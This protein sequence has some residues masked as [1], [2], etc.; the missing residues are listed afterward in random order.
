MKQAVSVP[1]FANGNILFHSDIDRCLEVTGADAV[2]SAE[3]NLYNPAIFSSSLTPI[4]API[5]PPPSSEVPEPRHWNIATDTGLHP[6]HTTLALEYL[7]IVKSLKTP[8]SNGAIKAHLFKL[9]RPA[10][11]RET[12]IRDRLGRM[13]VDK[14]KER[15]CVNKWEE[16]TSEL[17]ARMRRDAI[18]ANDKSIDELITIDPATGL[19]ILP[20]WVAQPYF[21]PLPPNLRESQGSN[22]VKNSSDSTPA[23]AEIEGKWPSGKIT[24]CLMLL[25]TGDEETSSAN[26]RTTSERSP[27]PA[28]DTSKRIKLESSPP[29]EFD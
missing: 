27:E 2:M 12:D 22:R 5:L 29:R 28:D 11:S 19:K 26:K 21:R 18:A 23:N 17:D 9:F 20:H 13:R 15:E 16:V 8:T 7:A 25:V 3:G 14:G 10:L 6:A 4:P 1:V 24:I